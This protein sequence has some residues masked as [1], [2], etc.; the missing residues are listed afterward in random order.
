MK[1]TATTTFLFAALTL[2]TPAPIAGPLVPETIPEFRHALVDRV[3]A[4]LPHLDARASKPKGSK[5]GGND[6]SSAAVSVS[7]SGVMMMS[8]LG[9]GV[10]E[11][12]RLWN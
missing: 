11:V 5:G 10:I 8:A 9:L 1:L 2:A 3:A 4:A 6:T 7:P 12:A